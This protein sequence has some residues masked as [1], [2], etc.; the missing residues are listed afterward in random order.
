MSIDW[1]ENISWMESSVQ[2]GLTREQ[3]K[4]SPEYDETRV[5]RDY[6]TRLHE[7]YGRPVYWDI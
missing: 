3:I 5:D 1:I 6:E 4:G 7:H 2:V